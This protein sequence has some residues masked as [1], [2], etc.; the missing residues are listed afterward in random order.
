MEQQIKQPKPL[1]NHFKTPLG[2]YFYETNRNEIVVVN[3]KL[4]KYI[5]AIMNDNEKEIQQTEHEIVQ[6]YND[7]VDCGYFST[8]RVK[9]I[10]HPETDNLELLLERKIDSIT[11][12]VTQNCNLRCSYCVYSENDYTSQRS[13]SEKTMSLET[14]KKAVDF[15]FAHS[16]DT[17]KP[18]ISFYGGEPFLSL[19]LI[20]QSVDYA[21]KYLKDESLLLQLQQMAHY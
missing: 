9:E 8:H 16:I 6:Q 5:D 2:Y 21:K 10:K 17:K 4:Y 7:L 18:N 12:Q 11:L 19:E 14:A 15:F 20:K 13:H 1:I 3:E